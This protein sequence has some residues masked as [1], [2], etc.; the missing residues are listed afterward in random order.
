MIKKYILLIIVIS[1]TSCAQEIGHNFILRNESATDITGIELAG[2]FNVLTNSEGNI[3]DL[4]YFDE[5]AMIAKIDH[6]RSG[7]KTHRYYWKAGTNV[8]FGNLPG[9]A[10]FKL[11]FVK[12]GGS[13]YIF[14]FKGETL[15]TSGTSDILFLNDRVEVT[16][17]I[18]KESFLLN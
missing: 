10:Y 12:S 18:C 7:A 15:D 8:P 14:Y 6:L 16:N 11:S 2:D 13:N 1:I 3:Q 5:N 17:N 4:S 9:Q